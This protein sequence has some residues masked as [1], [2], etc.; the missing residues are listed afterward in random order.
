MCGWETRTDTWSMDG[1]WVCYNHSFRHQ[2]GSYN[3]FPT[4]KG[5]Q[6]YRTSSLT[7]RP[8]RSLLSLSCCAKEV[9]HLPLLQDKLISTAHGI[10]PANS[11]DQ[12]APGDLDMESRTWRDGLHD[13][14]FSPTSRVFLFLPSSINIP[15]HTYFLGCC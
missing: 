3:I 8:S 1:N 12:L 6:L 13:S 5:E 10:L 4:D 14:K 9:F 15:S 7:F 2:W 11:Q